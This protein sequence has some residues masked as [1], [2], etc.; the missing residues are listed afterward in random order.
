MQ[1]KLSSF[2]N[3]KCNAEWNSDSD[4]YSDQQRLLQLEPIG[5]KKSSRFTSIAVSFG[6][7]VVGVLRPLTEG[8]II[9]YRAFKSNPKS[10]K[11]F[12]FR[13]D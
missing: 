1:K 4:K 6:H 10:E 11:G 8:V 3:D 12:L 9:A 13:L 5:G 2:P 7:T